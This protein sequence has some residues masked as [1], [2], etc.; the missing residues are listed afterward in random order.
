LHTTIVLL[1][2]DCNAWA[3]LLNVLN[4]LFRHL[5][6]RTGFK[7]AA[8]LRHKLLR[9]IDPIDGSHWGR[10]AGKVCLQFTIVNLKNI[11]TMKT[12]KQLQSDVMD[13]LQ[14]DPKLNAAEIGV[15]VKGSIVTLSGHVDSYTEKLAAEE[16]AKR[17]KDVKGIVEE[18][19][20]QL[21]HDGQRTDQELAAATLN[22][23]RWNSAIPDQNIKVEVENGWVTLEGHVDWQFQKDAAINAVKD[24]IGLKGVTNILNI[25]PRVNIPVIRDT[26]KKALER[27]A[28]VEADKIQIETSGSKVIL[29]GKARS[30]TERNEVER[31]AWS[32]PGV[33]EVED[34]LVI[35]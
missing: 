25:Q 34:D 9:I 6:G 15:S 20:V 2:E 35:A 10:S 11:T 3:L 32:A 29:R 21:L 19:T 17:V 26:I 5:Y 31:A 18:I 13:E 22:A 12:D 16:A 28:D 27:S 8:G 24:I 1:P 7:V 4:N 23:L 33:A 14:W 30:W